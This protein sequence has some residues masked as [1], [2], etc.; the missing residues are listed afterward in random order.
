MAI[1][2]QKKNDVNYE[3]ATALNFNGAVQI[4]INENDWFRR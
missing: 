4:N 1:F 3:G 2:A